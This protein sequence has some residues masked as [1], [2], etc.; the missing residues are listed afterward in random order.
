MV[1]TPIRFFNIWF[2]ESIHARTGSAVTESER[3]RKIR[4]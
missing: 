4:E 3:P 2:S 1:R